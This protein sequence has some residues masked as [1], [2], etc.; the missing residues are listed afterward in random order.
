MACAAL[1]H[2][3]V[4]RRA[5]ISPPSY[6]GFAMSSAGISGWAHP[7]SDSWPGQIEAWVRTHVTALVVLAGGV[8]LLLA[9]LVLPDPWDIRVPLY[10][11]VPDWTII[12]PK[13]ALYLMPIA[14]PWGSLDYIDV[15]GLR[16]N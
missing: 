4:V 9:L 14:V 7:R 11:G 13:A 5:V 12:Q 10:L 1:L 3:S 8:F 6:K 16:L 15:G 2:G